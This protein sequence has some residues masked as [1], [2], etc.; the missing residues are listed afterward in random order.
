M[1][2]VAIRAAGKIAQC[3]ARAESNDYAHDCATI[4]EARNSETVRR[5]AGDD[6]LKG[7]D[8][9]I[10]PEPFPA[11]YLRDIDSL[12]PWRDTFQGLPMV[13]LAERMVIHLIAELLHES[14]EPDYVALGLPGNDIHT[15]TMLMG[16]GIQDRPEILLS[17]DPLWPVEAA[18]AEAGTAAGRFVASSNSGPLGLIECARRVRERGARKAWI[19][20]GTASTVAMPFETIILGGGDDRAPLP[21]E[22]NS[23]GHFFAE[24]GVSFELTAQ[25]ANSATAMVIGLATG[26]FHSRTV[27]RHALAEVIVRALHDA[28]VAPEEPVFVDLYG[29]GNL[30]DDSAELSAVKLVRKQM[31]NV[32]PGYLKGDTHYV[33]GSHGLMGLWRLLTAWQEPGN[34]EDSLPVRRKAP[35][36]SSGDEHLMTRPSDYNVFAFPCFSMNGDCL[37]V[38]VRR[39]EAHDRP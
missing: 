18:G 13:G 27:N 28:D 30:I 8:F 16:L 7:Q 38:V 19:V 33:V 39:G 14:G 34:D 35:L 23:A 5:L 20:T 15:P 36:S 22:E 29:R 32:R 31:P 2:N 24:G 11:I 25:E 21:F 6:D 4:W 3:V 10:N 1:I 17:G 37:V 26:V 12:L 9:Q